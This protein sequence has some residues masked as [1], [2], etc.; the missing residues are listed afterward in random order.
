MTSDV[1]VRPR[2]GDTDIE[3]AGRLATIDRPGLSGGAITPQHA[4]VRTICRPV[5]PT[6]STSY[7]CWNAGCDPFRG[8]GGSPDARS[9]RADPLGTMSPI[10]LQAFARSPL[11]PGDALAT[12]GRRA[13][14]RR[15]EEACDP[16]IADKPRLAHRVAHGRPRALQRPR[17]LGHRMLTQGRRRTN[18]GRAAAKHE[19]P[20]AAPTAR[21][22]HPLDIIEPVVRQ[23]HVRDRCVD[24]STPPPHADGVTVAIHVFELPSRASHGRIS[25]RRAGAAVRERGGSASAGPE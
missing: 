4:V 22:A 5:A 17:R 23:R 11:P 25:R 3:L 14:H 12:G 2:R 6:H 1:R 16:S 20:R 10:R 21:S 7:G 15:P 24:T 18:L 13:S 19:R 8:S 9:V